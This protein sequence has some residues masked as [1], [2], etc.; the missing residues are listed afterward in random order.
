M[1]R[2]FLFLLFFASILYCQTNKITGTIYNA[3][4]NEPVPY[5]NIRIAET[6][7]GTSSNFDG[8]FVLTLTDNK[9]KLI[10]TAVGF[11]KKEV[12]INSNEVGNLKIGMHPEPIQLLEIVV[13]VDEDPSYRIIREAIKRK[14][15]NRAG[16]KS[17][18]FDL[19]AKDIFLSSGKVAM[20]SENFST[21]YFQTGKPEKLITRSVHITENE[22]K[23][24]LNFDQNILNKMYIDFTDD[25]LNVIGNKVFLPLANNAFD[26]Y[27]FHLKQVKQSGQFHDCF[28]EV[29][30]RSNIQPLLMGTIV[31]EDSSY[32][33]KS[34]NLVNNPGLRFPFVN[35]LNIEFIQNRER[36]SNYWLPTYLKVVSGLKLNFSGIIGTDNIAM[37]QVAMF[38]NYK[39]NQIIPDSIYNLYSTLKNDTNYVTKSGKKINYI[40]AETLSRAQIDSIRPIPL[41]SQELQAYNEI[42]SSKTVATQIKFTGLLSG[43]ATEAVKREGG[44]EGDGIMKYVGKVFSVLYLR[45][46]KVNGIVLGAHYN[47]TFWD[48]RFNASAAAGYAFGRKDFEWKLA[49]KAITNWGIFSSID[50]EMHDEA[51][52]W[53]ML[54]PYPDLASSINVL[55]GFN[56][57]YNY[58]KSKGFSFGLTFNF[59]RNSFASLKYIYDEQ[60]SL[61]SLNYQSIFSSNRFVH[62]NPAISQGKDNRLSFNF[63][64]GKDPQAFQEKVYDGITAQVDLS[65]P[66]LGSDFNYK[67]IRF[68]SQLSFNTFFGEL[69]S[70]PYFAL[71]LEGGGV[72][73][74]YAIQHTI[75]PNSALNFYSPFLS[76]KGLT[77]YEYTGNKFIA[78]HAEHNW[79]TII[80]Q[81]TGLTFFADYFIDVITGL[82]V[83]KMWNET[84]YF[85]TNSTDKVYWEAYL[86]FGR[87]LGLGRIDFCY[88]ANS[89]FVVKIAL[90][91]LF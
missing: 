44:N 22:K 89:N 15:K 46:N 77:P 88:G 75:T 63:V 11:R 58:Y 34:I 31:I 62:F 26:Y 38:T 83:L 8:K 64:L 72:F 70:A 17:L 10:F 9:R 78:L 73:G 69:F 85:K 33:L 40:K 61:T 27:D 37:N 67:K 18:E 6:A 35:D 43:V 52:E 39:L 21:G 82:S 87:I 25:T 90:S 16:L 4:T 2:Q 41:T 23:N 68:I 19:F 32:A 74:D 1:F 53:Q 86:G 48:N 56:D 12:E 13:G 30:P 24:A 79:R 76:F 50:L 7:H 81:G 49:L 65:N 42:D 60:K 5:V 47:K 84:N 51:L 28:I 54:N 20:V 29:I 36:Y 57:Y 91:T 59:D 45:D 71:G 55:V 80:F 3:E 66:S 14:E